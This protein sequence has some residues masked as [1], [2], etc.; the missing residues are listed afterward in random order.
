MQYTRHD[1]G[2]LCVCKGPYY[3]HGSTLIPA[4]GN[5]QIRFEV[6]GE[7]TYPFRCDR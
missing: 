1:F 3:E 6:W 7:I 4:W 2:H 5:N